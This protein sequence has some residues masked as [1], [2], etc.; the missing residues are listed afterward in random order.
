M[1][2]TLRTTINLM[3]K[4]MISCVTMGLHILQ[5]H[6][7]GV[8]FIIIIIITVCVKCVSHLCHVMGR[9]LVKLYSHMAGGFFTAVPTLSLL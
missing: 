1:P 6:L 2:R 3:G 8:V 5:Y 9:I 4:V 7:A